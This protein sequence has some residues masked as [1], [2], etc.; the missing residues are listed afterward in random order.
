MAVE[1]GVLVRAFAS[2]GWGVGRALGRLARLPALLHERPL[3]G[4]AAGGILDPHRA[5]DAADGEQHGHDEHRAMEPS[6]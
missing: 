3:G 6:N 2:V 5:E 1:G 4:F